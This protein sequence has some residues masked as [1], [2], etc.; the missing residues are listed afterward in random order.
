[1]RVKTKQAKDNTLCFTDNDDVVVLTCLRLE[2]CVY[3]WWLCICEWCAYTGTA[4]SSH[5]I[6]MHTCP[7]VSA[8]RYR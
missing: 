5:S 2:H 1:M 3:A 7:S 8:T 4:Q 6:L